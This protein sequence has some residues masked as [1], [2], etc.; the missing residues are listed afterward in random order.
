[1]QYIKSQELKKI[2]KEERD[3]KA[4]FYR[5]IRKTSKKLAL[6]FYK[7]DKQYHQNLIKNIWS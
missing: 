3:I 6:A 1:M 4:K 5:E 2:I 7:F